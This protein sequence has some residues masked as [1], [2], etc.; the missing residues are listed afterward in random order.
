MEFL[1][2]NYKD[3]KYSVDKIWIGPDR[4]G[5]D[6]GTDHIPDHGSDHGSREK[7][8]ISEDYETEASNLVSYGSYQANLSEINRWKRS[9]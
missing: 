6:H 5:S 1:C 4:T 8:K 9:S 2:L 7:R 3:Y